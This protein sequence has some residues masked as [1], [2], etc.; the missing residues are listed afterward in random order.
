MLLYCGGGGQEDQTFGQH[1]QHGC[2]TFR[3]CVFDGNVQ[4]IILLQEQE[5]TDRNKEETGKADKLFHVRKQPGAGRGDVPGAFPEPVDIAPFPGVDD[6]GGEA[7]FGE[8]ASAQEPLPLFLENR[9]AFTGEHAL[10]LC[11]VSTRRLKQ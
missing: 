5:D 1:A 10:T 2:G 7:A 11:S 3:H 9:A 6:L 8:I 4:D